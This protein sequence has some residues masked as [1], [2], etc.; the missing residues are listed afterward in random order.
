MVDA[1]EGVLD[2]A[3]EHRDV[4]TQAEP[5]PDGVAESK[6]TSIAPALSREDVRTIQQL[7]N[8]A[9]TNSLLEEN[10]TLAVSLDHR[11]RYLDPLNHIQIALLHRTRDKDGAE[12]PW[13]DPL[14]RTINAIAAGQRN[15][16]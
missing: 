9:D 15:T 13:R 5:V 10:P 8:V 16:G 7:L 14:L 12:S 3:I 2:V 6:P 4:R 1:V 11:K